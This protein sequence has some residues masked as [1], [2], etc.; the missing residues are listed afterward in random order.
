M[1]FRDDMADA[2]ECIIDALGESAS[3]LPSDGGTILS[4]TLLFDRRRQFVETE[5]GAIM[6]YE[7]LAFGKESDLPSG[8][9]T[10]DRICVGS[11][12]YDIKTHEVDGY[13]EV[14]MMLNL[15]A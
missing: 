8:Y 3:Y 14:R 5:D 4:I 12:E 7:A 9:N 10:D 2:T 6:H 13:G 15:R 11:D 1:T